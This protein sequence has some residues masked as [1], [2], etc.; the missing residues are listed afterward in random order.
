MKIQANIIE[1]NVFKIAF[2]KK[3]KKVN[4]VKMVRAQLERLHPK[5]ISSGV[6]NWYLDEFFEEFIC[7]R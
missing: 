5:K 4:L 6:D 2:P 3:K 7:G 1:L